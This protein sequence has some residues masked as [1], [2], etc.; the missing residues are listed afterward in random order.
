MSEAVAELLATLSR[1]SAI[2]ASHPA[3]MPPPVLLPFAVRA[4]I[5][6]IG[7]TAEVHICITILNHIVIT[8]D[9]HAARNGP[10]ATDSSH[11]L[12]P[13][14]PRPIICRLPTFR[15]LATFNR[16]S[17]Y[18]KSKASQG[19]EQ[20]DYVGYVTRS[21]KPNTPKVDDETDPSDCRY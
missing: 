21:L 20:S 17:V 16:H 7:S 14:A 9:I 19:D 3:P 1:I 10:V 13:A 18:G 8:L 12:H 2:L 5:V 6:D 11:S 4:V 15:R